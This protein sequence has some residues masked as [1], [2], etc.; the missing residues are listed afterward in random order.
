MIVHGECYTNLDGYKREEWPEQFVKVPELGE[1]IRS[2]DEADLTVVHITHAMIQVGNDTGTNME[3]K[4]G[5]IL[6]LNL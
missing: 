6:E 3:Y 4:P 1:S 5:V 2:K